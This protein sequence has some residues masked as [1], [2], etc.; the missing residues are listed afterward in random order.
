MQLRPAGELGGAGSL[1]RL[2]GES[3]KCGPITN[4]EEPPPKSQR[5]SQLASRIE[6]KD[7]RD[8]PYDAP[9]KDAHR[10]PQ[11][12]GRE[13]LFET[14]P[15]LAGDAI[16]DALLLCRVAAHG[17]R[18]YDPV[19]GSPPDLSVVFEIG[20][21]ASRYCRGPVDTGDALCS[22][23]RVAIHKGQRVSLSV[24]DHDPFGA[25]SV[26]KG[27]FVYQGRLPVA[28]EDP[29]FEAECRALP[30]GAYEGRL[31]K[32][33]A[34][35]DR[36]LEQLARAMVPAADVPHWGYPVEQVDATRNAF[37]EVAAYVGW[38]G[39][40]LTVRRKRYDELAAGWLSA[41]SAAVEA[42]IEQLPAP[43]TKVAVG[44]E[45][46]EVTVIATTC[47]PKAVSGYG[48]NVPNC[49]VE[50]ELHDDPGPLT[51]GFNS[52]DGVTLAVVG[53]QGGMHLLQAV[54][55]VREGKLVE[56]M[57][58]PRSTER[59]LMTP[60]WAHWGI[61]VPEKVLLFVETDGQTALLRL[62]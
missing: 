46:L 44:K 3:C 47:H 17:G 22:L 8:I 12:A 52:V 41:V 29:A 36:A 38:E 37:R 19:D 54:G 49:V 39:P 25:D 45:A 58:E 50:L 16:E 21:G 26:G 51:V 20:D 60:T 1:L 14:T 35:L 34:E 13:A 43:G 61:E 56:E 24:F 23:S 9:W 32:A 55:I 42:K 27:A 18:I 30:P 7:N 33:T 2:S 48:N 4:R 10:E 59:V 5:T 62:H 53:E 57:D 15:P 6:G 40:E 31:A 28:I 11:V